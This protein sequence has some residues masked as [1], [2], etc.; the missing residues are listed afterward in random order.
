MLSA[1]GKEHTGSEKNPPTEAE[2][3]EE[4]DPGLLKRVT[5]DGPTMPSRPGVKG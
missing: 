5:G 3:E 2:E 4:K 1:T